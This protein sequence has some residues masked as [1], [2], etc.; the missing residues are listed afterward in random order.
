MSDRK[1]RQHGYQDDDRD[2]R[3]SREGGNGGDRRPEREP[4]A[5]AGT[6]R[7]SSEGAKNP[8][9]MGY[10]SVAKCARCGAPVDGEILSLSK[11]EK[12][13]QA[14]HACIQCVNFDPSA[15]FECSERVPARISPKD[16]ANECASFTPRASWERATSSTP[17]PAASTSSGA[18]E[19]VSDAKK[20][21]EDLF[22]I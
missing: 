13:G 12:C 1:Y 10:R 6:R 21:F 17:A 15:R 18:P 3:P 14:L 20:A 7:M 8:R 16:A 9:M 19:S 22:K 4:G 11:C 2:R 5:P